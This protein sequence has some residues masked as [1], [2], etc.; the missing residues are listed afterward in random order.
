MRK[1]IIIKTR[2]N[3]NFGC[4]V[5]LISITGAFFMATMFYYDLD[6][7]SVFEDVCIIQN[8]ISKT[9]ALV[10]IYTDGHN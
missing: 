1:K 5:A 9:E 10:F 4:T 2:E 3:I 8:D 6:K 7:W